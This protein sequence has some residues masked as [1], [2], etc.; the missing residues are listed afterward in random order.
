MS[1][2]GELQYY[3]G[4][5]YERNKEAR[6]ITVTRRSYIE[7]VSQTFQSRKLHTCQKSVQ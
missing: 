3:L 4:V 2:L 1:N 7:K 6:T 5:E